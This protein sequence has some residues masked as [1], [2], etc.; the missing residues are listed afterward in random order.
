[1]CQCCPETLKVLSTAKSCH[2]ISSMITNGKCRGMHIVPLAG[3]RSVLRQLSTTPPA[4][5]LAAKRRSHSSAEEGVDIFL[6][7]KR[8]KCCKRQKMA[9]CFC[10]SQKHTALLPMR[11]R[12]FTFPYMKMHVILF[13]F[14]QMV[15]AVR[16]PIILRP[17]TRMI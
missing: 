12:R 10:G 4:S 11:I 2:S 13:H 3:T 8:F 9:R 6:T 16:R 14:V 7:A 17:P 5:A 1:M 15:I